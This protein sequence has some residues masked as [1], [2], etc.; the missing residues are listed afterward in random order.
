MPISK[1]TIILIAIPVV[2]VGLMIAGA[3]IT[4]R[5]SFC[6][7]CHNMKI[8]YNTLQTSSHRELECVKCHIAPGFN[9]YV[10][11]KLNGLSQVVV[12][13][14]GQKPLIYHAQVKDASCLREGCHLEEEILAGSVRS[15]KGIVFQ[16]ATHLR[17]VKD[18]ELNC[19]SCHSEIVHGR[20][21]TSTNST[22][23]TC[24]F[25]GKGK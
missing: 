18:I 7:T 10:R 13:T 20:Q 4:S 17:P 24:H 3:E 14:I 23:F 12:Y 25:K 6:G 8:Y 9:N 21:I 5:N 22:C 11:A 19:T 16:H 1:K 15:K 2:I